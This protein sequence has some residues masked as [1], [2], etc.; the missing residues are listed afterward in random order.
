MTEK[1]EQTERRQHKRFH[2]QDGVVAVLGKPVL[3]VGQIM[4]ISLKGLSFRYAGDAEMP[5]ETCSLD[6]L[7]RDGLSFLYGIPCE[8]V[9]DIDWSGSVP[10]TAPPQRRIG[11]RFGALTS[12]QKYRLEDF[13]KHYTQ[14]E[15]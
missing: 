8:T 9:Y 14:G 2:V 6:I 5:G 4:D 3:A 11:V 10:F 15:V 12:N 13:I 1:R 7:F